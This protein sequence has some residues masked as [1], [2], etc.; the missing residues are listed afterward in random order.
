MNH[1]STVMMERCYNI[2]DSGLECTMTRIVKTVKLTKLD[3]LPGTKLS[4]ADIDCD[5]GIV[6]GRDDGSLSVA[7]W[8]ETTQGR[9]SIRYSYKIDSQGNYVLGSARYSGKTLEDLL[10]GIG[11][12]PP[13]SI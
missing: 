7:V 8:T 4:P 2:V 11:E 10:R 13:P 5:G 6:V 1:W 9:P 3:T 12:P